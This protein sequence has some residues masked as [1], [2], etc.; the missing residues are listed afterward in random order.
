MSFLDAVRG[1]MPA[2]DG[3][4]LEKRIT[5]YIETREDDYAQD[6]F[7]H[8]SA[9]YYMC[10]R[11]EVLKRVVPKN[12]LPT[13]RIDVVTRAKFDIGHALHA[14]YQNKYLGPMGILKGVWQCL[15]CGSK[16]GL[17]VP[18]VRPDKCSKCGTSGDWEYHECVLASKEWNIVGK[19][20]GIISAGA[21]DYVLDMK[22]CDPGLF[23]KLTK[24]WPSNTYQVQIYMWLL[25]IKTGLL[26]YIDKSS[27]GPIP[28]REFPVE[29]SDKTVDDVKGKITSFRL[30]MNSRTLPECMCGK[31]GFGASCKAIEA[32]AGVEKSVKDWAGAVV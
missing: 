31:R 21:V 25:G 7:F 8:P 9:L 22:T 12:M 2:D 29:F 3:T 27:N 30:S 24:P 20:D 13:E 10:P 11:C 6:D 26:L 19:I 1:I 18:T 4:I 28:V 5:K 32:V 15:E 16:E 23:Q 14:W 17:E